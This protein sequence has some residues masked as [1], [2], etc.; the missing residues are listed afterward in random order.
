[1]IVLDTRLHVQIYDSAQQVYQVSD[2]GISSSDIQDPY[3]EAVG[4]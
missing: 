4:P 1:M 3:I 2:A